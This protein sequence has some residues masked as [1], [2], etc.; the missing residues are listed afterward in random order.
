[1]LRKKANQ[2]S[3][4]YPSFCSSFTRLFSQ[5]EQTLFFTK[6]IQCYPL[7][8]CKFVKTSSF[9]YDMLSKAKGEPI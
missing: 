6:H 4:V 7:L 5:N 2:M 3:P 8:F 1:M 9:A